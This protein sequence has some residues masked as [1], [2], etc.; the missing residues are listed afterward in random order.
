MDAIGW[1]GTSAGWLGFAHDEKLCDLLKDLHNIPITTSTLAL[2]RLLKL[3]R[4]SLLGLVTPYTPD[5]NALIMANYAALGYPITPERARDMSITENHRIGAVD[6]ETL[7][8]MVR[9]VVEA[10]A[11]CVTT[12]C[13]NWNAAHLVEG[14]EREFGVPVFDS[15]S[16]VV[17]D[18]CRLVEVDMGGAGKWGR[19]FF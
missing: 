17:W 1:S 13:T 19:M 7:T 3:S 15:V 9:E 12:F 18:L 8:Q 16:A 6:G 5:M 2:N 4:I 10:G 14:W 11:D